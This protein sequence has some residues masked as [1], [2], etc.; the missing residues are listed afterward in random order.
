MSDENVPI[1]VTK[2]GNNA[3]KYCLQGE[4]SLPTP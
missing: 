2:I 1:L 4:L 3:E